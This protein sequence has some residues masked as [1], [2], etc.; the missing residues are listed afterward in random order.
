MKFLT[1][2]KDGGG[3]STVTGYWLVEIKSLFSICLL[4][5]EGQSRNAFHNHAFDCFS[6]VLSGLLRE[7]FL[8]GKV[9]Y[10]DADPTP[11]ITTRRH[12]HRVDSVTPVTWVLSFRGPWKKHWDE[13]HPETG[14]FVGLTHGRK[15]TYRK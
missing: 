13:F 10:H 1:R 12:F 6:W 15:E 14:Q 3:E 11:F 9:I 4:R 7:T 2:R 8:D 5:F